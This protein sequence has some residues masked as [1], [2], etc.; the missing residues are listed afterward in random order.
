MSAPSSSVC[1]QIDS[2]HSEQTPEDP[3]YMTPEEAMK[4][5]QH[6]IATASLSKLV[7]ARLHIHL[8]GASA[9]RGHTCA[10]T[11]H[12]ILH[13]SYCTLTHSLDSELAAVSILCGVQMWLKSMPGYDNLWD[14]FTQCFKKCLPDEEVRLAQVPLPSA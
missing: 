3:I 6:E 13:Y 1:A 10:R 11:G 14:V 5:K 4:M 2:E 9:P 8:M 7:Q 12:S